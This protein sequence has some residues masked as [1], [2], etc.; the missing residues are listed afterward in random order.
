MI[1][2]IFGYNIHRLGRE[3][4]EI[5][6]LEKVL[7]KTEGEKKIWRDDDTFTSVFVSA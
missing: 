7:E 2:K 4:F 5:S 6:I 1:V 3:S